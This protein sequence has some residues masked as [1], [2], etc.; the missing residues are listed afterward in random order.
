MKANIK[1]HSYNVQ[2]LNTLRLFVKYQKSARRRNVER[3]KLFMI[4]ANNLV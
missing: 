2:F 1:V 3:F 4:F